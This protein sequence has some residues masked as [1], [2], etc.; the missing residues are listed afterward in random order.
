MTRVEPR[1]GT[2]WSGC[3]ACPS[4]SQCHRKEISMRLGHGCREKEKHKGDICRFY[5][6]PMRALLPLLVG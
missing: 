4:G 1:K 6:E 2:R 3:L 5:L